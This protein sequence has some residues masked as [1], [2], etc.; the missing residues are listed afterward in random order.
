MNAP[1]GPAKAFLRRSRDFL[2]P[3]RSLISGARTAGEAPLSPEDFRSLTFITDPVCNLC[4][5]PQ[6]YDA[7][8][9]TVCAACTAKPP[10]WGRA[11]A[12]LVYDDLS[13]RP[14]LDLKRAGRRDG[15]ELLAGWM[16][17]AGAELLAEA[18][19]IVPVPLHYSRLVLRGYNQSAWLAQ[20]VGRQAGVRVSVDT[21]KRTRRTPSQ[22]GL[23][24]RA[25]R[26]NVSGAFQV[27]RGRLKHVAGR[28][29]VLVDDV[30][31]TGAT[32]SA[33]TRALKQAGARQ[34]D[35]IVLAR[36]VRATD[37]TI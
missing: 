18:D 26:R 7:G 36:V 11:R 8:A 1:G 2:W 25:R 15:L 28:N 24:A 22:A 20:A 37:L 29:V 17:R 5:L 32:L 14:V 4:G 19:L 3:P 33:C 34:I 16:R 12:A 30:L 27:R 9:E 21:L 13:R 10:R 35:V 6:D 31:T 23:T